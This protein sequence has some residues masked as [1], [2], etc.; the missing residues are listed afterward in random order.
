M[1]R[2]AKL[3][4]ALVFVLS[5]TGTS[6]AWATTE[7]DSVAVKVPF[8]FGMIIGVT[9]SGEGQVG[10]WF[11]GGEPKGYRTETHKASSLVGTSTPRLDALGFMAAPA[12]SL[13][14]SRNNKDV[15]FDH[16]TWWSRLLPGLIVGAPHPK[17]GQTKDPALTS[18]LARLAGMALKL[19]AHGAVRTKRRLGKWRR[20]IPRFGR[21]AKAKGNSRE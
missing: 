12:N 17:G 14:V 19:S 9:K 8:L 10:Y 16:S 18:P 11:G 4:I 7:Q 15:R 20:L 1:N 5:S 6:S 2:S 3:S 13:P 21:T